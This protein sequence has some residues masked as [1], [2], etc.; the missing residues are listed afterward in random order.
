MK[1]YLDFEKP[2]IELQRKLDDL[3]KHPG[4]SLEEEIGQIEKKIEETRRNIFTDL[5]PPVCKTQEPFG[6]RFAISVQRD[7]SPAE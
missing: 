6:D 5:S 1:H 2:I 4:I 3:R 7:S